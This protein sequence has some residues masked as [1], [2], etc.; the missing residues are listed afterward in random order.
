R[1]SY[2]LEDTFAAFEELK[3]AGKILSWG[4]SNFD[5]DDLDEALAVVGEGKIAC[6]QVLYHVQER[7][8]EHAVVPWCEAHEVAV[9]AYSPFGQGQ[10]PSASSLGGRVLTEIADAHGATSRQVALAFLTRRPL[11]FAIPKASSA[12]HAED[13]AGAGD[14]TL[15][16]AEIARIDE[17]FPLG[18]RKSLPMI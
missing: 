5:A 7:A 11:L 10:F 17:A 16:A 12:A 3:Q 15:S 14:L 1:G 4:V 13:N 2:E 18:R 9:V 8:I 6:N